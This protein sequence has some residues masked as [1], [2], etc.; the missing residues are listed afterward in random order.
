MNT[1][2]RLMRLAD[3]NAKVSGTYFGENYSGTV[4]SSRQ[5]NWGPDYPEQIT[6]KFDTEQ[7]VFGMSRNV[8]LINS[9]DIDDGI[10][11]LS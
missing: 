4:E 1:A 6:I 7:F 3:N 5:L 9:R 2:T 10:H 8:I 11:T